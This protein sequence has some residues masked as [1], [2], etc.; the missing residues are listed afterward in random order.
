MS[1]WTRGVRVDQIKD[2]NF[3]KL[4]HALAEKHYGKVGL[5]TDSHGAEL[6]KEIPFSSIETFLDDL[7]EINSG[8]VWSLGKIYAYNKIA[9][10]GPFLHLDNDV[11]LWKKLPEELT[12]SEIFTQSFDAPFYDDFNKK[13]FNNAYDLNLL[14][15]VSMNEMPKDWEELMRSGRDMKIHNV[16]VFGGTNVDFIKK[17]SEYSLNMIKNKKYMPLFESDYY[18][19]K[20]DSDVMLINSCCLEQLNLVLFNEKYFNLKI[21]RLF[22][23]MMDKEGKSYMAYTHLM[24]TKDNE[25]V[26]KGIAQR[27]KFKPHFLELDPRITKEQWINGQ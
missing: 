1:F 3:W 4:S 15:L 2:I 6:L 27:V 20:T 22:D 9:D 23:D 25:S 16:G 14:N 7:K 21:N 12:N 26:R 19:E 11:F 18:D 13:I 10:R 24:R 5:I 8:K 17:Y